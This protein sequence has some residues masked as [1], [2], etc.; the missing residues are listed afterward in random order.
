MGLK[1]QFIDVG[2]THPVTGNWDVAINST[3]NGHSFD[4]PIG[5][6]TREFDSS[7]YLIELTTHGQISDN[8]DIVAGGVFDQLHGKLGVGRVSN[9]DMWRESIYLQGNYTPLDWLKL[10][11]GF[12]WNKPEGVASDISPRIGAVTNFHKAWGA[13]V[14]YGEAYRA[15]FGAESFI[16]APF[17][18]GNSKLQ[19]ERIATFDAQIFYHTSRHFAAFTY[20]SSKLSDSHA[21]TFVDGVNTYVNAGEVDFQ[22]LEFEGNAQFAKEL[23]LLGSISYQINE[24]DKGQKDVTFSPNLMAKVGASYEADKGYTVSLFNSH[25][26]EASKVEKFNLG[27]QEVNPAADSYDLLTANISFDIPKLLG[28]PTMPET[29]LSLYADNLLDE[30]IDFP[31]FNR[32]VVNT[33]PHHSGRAVY[34]MISVGL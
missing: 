15:A 33:I 27:T 16:D 8:V 3:Y 12:Q 26:G 31:E 2:Y 6:I 23:R 28:K 7:G 19:P 20:Y 17:L 24:D 18:K 34:G 22:G 9:Y 1:R 29:T 30:D 4:F 32:K 13:K 14:L 10:V 5:G 21:R 11:G 25:F